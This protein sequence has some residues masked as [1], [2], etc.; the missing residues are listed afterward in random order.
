MAINT[1]WKVTSVKSVKEDGGI[2]EARWSCVAQSDVAYDAST[3]TG[4][5]TASEGGRNTFVYDA[6]DSGFIA[7]D[8]VTEANVLSWIRDANKAVGETATQWKTRIETERTAKVQQQIDDKA[9]NSNALPW[10]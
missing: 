8:Q 3:D 9:A 7:L 6:S 4:G 2:I 1:T 10:S 5:E